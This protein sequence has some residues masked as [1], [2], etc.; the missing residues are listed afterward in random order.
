MHLPVDYFVH[1][2]CH[3]A[4]TTRGLA[5]IFYSCDGHLGLLKP[6]LFVQLC[7]HFLFIHF[8]NIIILSHCKFR[9]DHEN[10]P[11][12]LMNLFSLTIYANLTDLIFT[13]R[14]QLNYPQRWIGGQINRMNGCRNENQNMAVFKISDIL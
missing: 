7:F 10:H 2:L 5:S 11:V 12:E 1:C 9:E 8:L 3:P 13:P 14:T 6:Q 4:D